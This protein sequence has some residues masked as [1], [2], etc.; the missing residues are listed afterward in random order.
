LPESGRME[1]WLFTL[2][3]ATGEVCRIEKLDP[4]SGSPHELSEAEYATLDSY[5]A[6]SA[7]QSEPA[8]PADPSP[9]P[10]LIATHRAYWRG[11]ADCAALY[12][13]HLLLG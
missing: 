11:V 2:D 6:A 3:G 8:Q 1:Q 7:S 12:R 5:L 10:A 4:V 9:P 13:Q